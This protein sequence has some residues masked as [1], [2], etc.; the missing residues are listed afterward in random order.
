VTAIYLLDAPIEYISINI[1]GKSF[2]TYISDILAGYV[3]LP[4]LQ[5]YI[6]RL[7]IGLFVSVKEIVV[8]NFSSA[9]E[10]LSQYTSS[11]DWHRV[12]SFVTEN[13]GILATK[14]AEYPIK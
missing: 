4:A 13:L 5:S 9:T 6:E 3:S 7:G 2:N 12:L 1:F 10:W 11:I 8:K 14:T